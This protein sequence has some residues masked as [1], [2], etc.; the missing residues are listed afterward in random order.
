MRSLDRPAA[1]TFPRGT[2]LTEN[3]LNNGR[4]PTDL[5]VLIA[6]LCVL[7]WLISDL[8]PE[9]RDSLATLTG[10]AGLAVTR[11]PGRR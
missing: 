10:L 4:I 9:Q 8:T 2:P 11:L 5:I 7:Y 1:L 3:T 6:T